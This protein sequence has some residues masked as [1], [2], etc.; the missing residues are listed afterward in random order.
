MPLLRKS[1]GQLTRQ[2]IR[3]FLEREA[4]IIRDMFDWA[5]DGRCVQAICRLLNRQG[6]PQRGNRKRAPGRWWH[7]DV[8]EILRNP[9][10]MG[11]FVTYRDPRTGE[12]TLADPKLCPPPIV[13]PAVW[14]AAQPVLD[15][16][17]Q[18]RRPQ[19]KR[20]F[21][22]SGFLTCLKCGRMLTLR[23][24]GDHHRHGACNGAASGECDAKHIPAAALEAEV[25][26]YVQHLQA[27]PGMLREVA[28]LTTEDLLPQWRQA[29][30]RVGGQMKHWQ[31]RLKERG[32][33]FAT[34][35]AAVTGLSPART[36]S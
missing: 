5:A 22:L 2:D 24:P 7:S 3:E 32:A 16:Y 6:A 27:S 33:D 4:Q 1:H 18:R 12:E 19:V 20:Q 35:M 17:T 26:G 21:L 8:R 30:V 15:G 34:Y 10:Y 23:Q 28:R 9:A 11:R 25:W 14:Q 29:L 13:D 36:M 31:G